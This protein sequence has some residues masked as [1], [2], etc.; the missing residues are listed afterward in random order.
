[1]SYWKEFGRRLGSLGRRSRLHS[2][3]SDEM[4]FHIESRAE[5]LEQAGVPRRQAMEQAR[6]EFGSATRA[7]EDTH[8][9]WRINWLEDLG[10]DLRYAARAMRRSPGFALAAIF[11]L[12]LGIGAN[13]TI[14]SITTS[15]LFSQPSCRDAASLISIWE[16]GNS[17]SAISD[18]IYLR[19]SGVFEGTAGLNP[20]RELNWRHGDQSTRL[21]T[22]IVT[23]D[24]FTVLD[25]PFELGRGIARGEDST[26]VLS[27]RLW[28]NAFGRDPGVIGR[29]MT[30]DGR[31]YT[32]VGVLP[33]DHRNIF[34]FGFS[35]DIYAPV[36]QKDEIVG[37]YARMPKGMNM[38]TAR[39]RL[40]TVF[41]DLDRIDPKKDSKRAKNIVITQVTGIY[42]LAQNQIGP[43]IAFFAMLTFVVG[44]VLLIACTNV[45]GLL[46]ARAAGRSHELAVRLSLGAGRARIVRH[47]LA[48]SLLLSM[49]GAAAGLA[50]DLICARLIS[51]WTLP[52]PVPVQVVIK[53]DWRLLCFAIGLV[54]A[55]ALFC[56]LMPALKAVRKDVNI[57]LKQD[58]RQMERTSGLRS[59]M[60]A[61]Q[62]AIST[63]LLVTG[64]L[65]LH[66][67]LRAT[68][69][70]PGFDLQHT[71]WA[72]MRLVPS[73]YRDQA[74]QDALVRQALDRLRAL[75]QVE[76]AAI[77]RNVPLNDNCVISTDLKTDIS[78]EPTRA[79]YECNDVGPDYFRAIGIPLL[80]GRDFTDQ[81]RGGS[82]TAA[83]VNETF[84][85]EVFGTRDPIGHRIETW[86]QKLVIVG[87]VKDS[88][89]FTL[90]ERQRAAVYEPYVA[91][92]EKSNLQF[93]VRSSG[94][95]MQQ[96]KPI[97]EALLRLDSSAAIETKPMNRALGFALLPSQFGAAML[98]SI[99]ILG[100]VLAA[101]GLYG[102]LLYAVSRRTREIGVRVAL[103][104][105]PRA[106][107]AT[108]CRH[109]FGLTGIGLAAGL[110][111]AVFGTKPLAMFLVPGVS[112]SD[113]AAYATVVGVLSFVSIL[114]TVAPALRAL[115][116]DPMIALREE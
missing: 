113:P 104:A 105:T 62:I 95:P 34:G 52:L 43:I 102:M 67:L 2:E 69:M 18:Y 49:L 33:A 87:V 55:S 22:G 30:L 88:K 10:S 85:R 57:A 58:A 89:Y 38:A 101:I 116:V 8:D 63:L 12:A 70:S 26:V 74:K 28:N 54:L 109:S 35:P 80:R 94:A 100:L 5:E 39:E 17:A 99:G 73:E 6:R 59:V 90:G 79:R 111:L 51:S 82:E 46:L 93:I 83:I 77:T 106:V 40:K 60:M 32:I 1:M 107:L 3:L 36:T 44:L 9:S 75:P 71:V 15:F 114:A 48:E 14:F 53:P 64:F 78:R 4:Q 11:C 76:A 23:D 31:V 65:F 84:A 25:V 96:V 56:G 108:V 110:T 92:K 19:D 72:Y 41:Q 13:A 98:G 112:T 103:G 47:L 45:A 29:A 91:S 97:T 68:T 50:V 42:V 115:R 61:S 37:F 20:E 7:A 21:Y 27:H 16:G 66:N 24:Y 81:D 86:S